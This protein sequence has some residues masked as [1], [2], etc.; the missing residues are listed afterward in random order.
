M[1]QGE[2]LDVEKIRA[3]E[4]FRSYSELGPL[5]HRVAGTA[6]LLQGHQEQAI[7][8][9]SRSVEHARS[10]GY[11]VVEAESLQA[12]A[13]LYL[14]FGRWPEASAAAKRLLALGAAFPSARFATEAQFLAML[15][16]EGPLDP[17]VIATTAALGNV[18]PIAARRAQALLGYQPRLDAVDR[19]VLESVASKSKSIATLE[20]IAPSGPVHFQ[21]E[22]WGLDEVRQH[23]F[24]SDG[25]TVDFSRR[26]LHW[27]VLIAIA[28]GQGTASKEALVRQAWESADYHPLRDDAR[29]QMAIRKL[30]EEIEADASSP[31]RLVTVESGYGFGG[32][33]FRL[34]PNGTA[35]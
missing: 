3:L 4:P 31:L 19:R 30:R 21:T 17:A 22:A 13:D 5:F 23:V 2:P 12:Q 8:E 6:A 35:K 25:R 28:D 29:L 26:H 27:R 10:T 16:A 20:R 15:A 1:R 24:F 33:A 18:A 9:L 34:R 7:I 14:V 11:G 32:E